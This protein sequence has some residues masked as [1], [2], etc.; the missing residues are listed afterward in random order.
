MKDK[1]HIW[2]VIVAVISLIMIFVLFRSEYYIVSE[3]NGRLLF[4][5][6]VN[7]GE[8]FEVEFIH[9]LNLSPIVDV[10]EFAD[11]G[12]VLRKSMFSALGAGTPTPADFPGSELIHSDGMFKLIGIDKPMEAFSILTSDVPDHRVSFGER[13]ARLL[14]LVASGRS[15][16]IEVRRMSL[17]KRLIRTL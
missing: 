1:T 8:R 6:A 3:H 2:L 14:E 16:T 15:V 5:W 4:A 12:M 17:A 7:K 11:D 10:F 13:E 9:S